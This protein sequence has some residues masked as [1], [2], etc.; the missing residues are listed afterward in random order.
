MGEPFTA[1]GATT[2]AILI[3]N[4]YA[5]MWTEG[6][7][8][9]SDLAQIMPAPSDYPGDTAYRWKLHG[10]ANGSVTTYSEGD[11]DPDVDSQDWY[12]AAVSWSYLKG[13]LQVTGHARDAMGSNWGIGLEEENIL[14]AQDM[15]TYWESV[16]ISSLLDAIDS[17]TTYA[18]ITRGSATYF[19]SLETA[20]NA[21]VGY[22]DIINAIEAMADDGRGQMIS[23]LVI[24][25]NQ[26]TNIYNLTGGPAIKYGSPSDLAA[27]YFNQSFGGVIPIKPIRGLTDTVILGLNLGGDKWKRPRIRNWQTSFQGRSGD[28]DVYQITYG[29]VLV[30]KDPRVQ[31]KLTGCTA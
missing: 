17:T 7:E 12:N 13:M 29:D 4:L 14:L 21:P 2:G 24:P 28:S 11:P 1:A 25:W 16:A 22:Q 19:E 23:T 10:G 15:Q 20:I 5:D 6:I 30:C 27:G 31:F 26:A 8:R 18:G 3:K 9:K